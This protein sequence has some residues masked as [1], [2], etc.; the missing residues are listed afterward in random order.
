[1]SSLRLKA[2]FALAGMGALMVAAMAAESQVKR[3]DCP[4]G[5]A[6]SVSVACGTDP[7]AEREVARCSSG[8]C[9]R[10]SL[11]QQALAACPDALQAKN[12]N[13]TRSNQKNVAPPDDDADPAPAEQ[14]ARE[15]HEGNGSQELGRE[16]RKRNGSQERSREGRNPQTGKE[17]KIPPEDGDEGEGED[18][19]DGDNGAGIA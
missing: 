17:I 3:G 2:I 5:Q 6:V 8:C 7:E 11:R 13:S 14:R 1:M 15:G 10:K 4:D 18:N 12:F 16:G 9:N 19:D